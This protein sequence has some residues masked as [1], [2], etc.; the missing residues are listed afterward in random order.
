M[1]L[2]ISADEPPTLNL[3]S[4]IDVLFLLIIFFMAGTQFTELERN[5]A[6]Q[7]PQVAQGKNLAA[8]TSRRTIGVHRDGQ[9]TLDR[10]LVTLE[11]LSTRLAEQR[12]V[13]PRLTVTVRGDGEGAFQHVAS[14]L[15]ACRAVGVTDLGITVRVGQ[16]AETD[17]RR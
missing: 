12:R 10:Q 11:E 17:K 6:L 4:M 15:A 9:I 7:V 2:K 13:N 8:A 14:V 1:P 5:I 3:T 16:G